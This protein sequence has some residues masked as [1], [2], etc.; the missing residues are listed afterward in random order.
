MKI[1]DLEEVKEL[2]EQLETN[3]DALAEIRS[4]NGLYAKVTTSTNRR[5]FAFQVEGSC[6]KSEDI[7]LVGAIEK[8]VAIRL[9]KVQNRLKELGVKL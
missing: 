3:E 2:V 7:E 9:E 6:T 8:Y 4:D 5:L 1:E